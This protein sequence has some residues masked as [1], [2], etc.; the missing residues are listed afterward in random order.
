MSLETNIKKWVSLDNDIKLLSQQI[1]E[2]RIEKNSYNSTIL[3]YIEEKNLE[4][5]TIKI[6]NG[7]LKFIDVNQQQPL[8]Y[9]FICECLYNYFDNIND[10]I[11]H[12]IVFYYCEEIDKVVY[13]EP[14]SNESDELRKFSKSELMYDEWLLSVIN[15]IFVVDHGQKL[16][17]NI[18]IS[19]HK[20]DLYERRINSKS[21]RSKEN[22]IRFTG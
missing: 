16:K 22:F 12:D 8:T 3:E 13:C 11:G 4:N 19:T 17:K 1:K 9:K 5:A 14:T 10:S 15:V 2:L 18:F 21:Y 20:H 7:K 6:G